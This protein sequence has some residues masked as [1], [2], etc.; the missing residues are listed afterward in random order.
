MKRWLG[1][2]VSAALMVVACSGS[3]AR[4]GFG[5]SSEDPAAGGLGGFGPGG[6]SSSGGVDPKQCA[7]AEAVATKPPVDVIVSVD[8]SGSMSDDIANVKANI[9]KLSDFLKRTGLDHRVVMIGTPGTGSYDVCVPPPLGAPGCASNGNQFRV[10][11]RN[12]QSNDTLTII[13]ST[14]DQTSGAM[15]WRSFLRPQALKVFV[16]I[17][18]DNSYQKA[19]QFDPELLAK[20]RGLFGTAAD[21]RY[22]FYPITGAA[23]FPSE[24]TCGRNAVNNG[25]EYL[26]LAKL[27]RGKWFP[28]CLT[29]FAP[30][31][32]EIGKSV[33]DTVA[34][35][36]DVP[37]PTGGVEIDFDRVNVS[38]QP[39]NGQAARDILQDPSKPCDK[40][41]DGWQYNADRTKILLC[42]AACERVRSDVGT[43]V[44]V[45]F[46]CQTRVK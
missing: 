12:V 27:T 8:Q 14:L 46:G 22:K 31:F 43:K 38:A 25:K 26:E 20:G 34:C 33:A 17:T 40:G 23:A 37:K 39:S 24:A 10:V 11:N 21:R 29:D 32:E 28:I 16:P 35:E 30:V 1:S 41:A 13:L 19:T 6:A 15:E 7:K 2:G 44:S 4:S 3:D 45:Q 5:E 42:G 9:N 36:L 18:D